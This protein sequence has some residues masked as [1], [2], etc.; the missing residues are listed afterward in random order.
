MVQLVLLLPLWLAVTAI[1]S[2]TPKSQD[3]Q[4]RSDDN[5]ISR[6]DLSSLADGIVAGV[7][8]GAT[9]LVGDRALK[10]VSREK[11]SKWWSGE[12]GKGY[13][14]L[15]GQWTEWDERECSRRKVSA[16]SSGIVRL[17]DQIV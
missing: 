1:A 11:V 10:E 5:E 3:T 12:G 6:R 17:V 9:F 13:R 16:G 4:D 7:T 14:R 2:P 8:A 15:R